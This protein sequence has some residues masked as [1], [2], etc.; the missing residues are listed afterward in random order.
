MT[1]PAIRVR[2]VGVGAVLVVVIGVAE[3]V[4]LFEGSGLK[5]LLKVF[6]AG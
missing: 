6:G 5:L 3:A 1:K 2:G 4:W